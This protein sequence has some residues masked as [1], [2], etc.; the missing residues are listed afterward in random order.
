MSESTKNKSEAP[1]TLPSGRK[2]YSKPR[3]LS[4]EKIEGRANV[5]DPLAGGKATAPACAILKS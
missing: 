2:A 3:I 4:R 1:A 5:C